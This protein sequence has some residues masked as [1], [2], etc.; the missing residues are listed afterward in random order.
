MAAR[1][2]HS[3]VVREGVKPRK[4]AL[5]GFAALLPA[6]A[7]LTGIGSAVASPGVAA[8]AGPAPYLTCV[9]SGLYSF[10]PPGISHSGSAS[11]KD[12]MTGTT[13]VSL[14]QPGCS[15]PAPIG[16]VLKST[17]STQCTG[18][19]TPVARCQPGRY[20]VDV[21]SAWVA[22]APS[23][24]LAGLKPIHLTDGTHQL[25]L[26]PTSVTALLGGS[27]GTELGFEFRGTV[28]R[29]AGTT[30]TMTYCLGADS[31][32]AASGV[33]TKDFA[34]AMA[35]TASVQPTI[36]TATIDPTYSRLVIS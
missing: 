20:V 28:A 1:R 2:Q 33:F 25:K 6:V 30:F 15:T 24:L 12:T 3:D 27:C 32:N 8:A 29:P 14:S 35:G 31:G 13:S 19:G 17:S 4:G 18:V 34:T 16:E 21:L 9:V 36:S 23:Q 26:V 11:S 7:G 10:S 5:I 22:T